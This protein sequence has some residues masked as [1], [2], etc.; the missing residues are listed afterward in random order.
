MYRSFTLLNTIRPFKTEAT[1]HEQ[2][3]IFYISLETPSAIRC[4]ENNEESLTSVIKDASKTLKN[5]RVRT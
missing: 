1:T 5:L 4:D 2:S 3:G